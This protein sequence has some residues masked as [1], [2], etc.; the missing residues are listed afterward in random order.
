MECPGCINKWPRV[1][2]VLSSKPMPYLQIWKDKWGILAER[3]VKAAN[4]IGTAVHKAI[5]EE[6]HGTTTIRIRHMFEQWE[7]WAYKNN[8]KPISKETHVWSDKHHYHGTFDA[9]GTLGASDEVIL[10]DWKTSSKLKPDMALQ[11]SAYAQ[12][13]EEMTEVKLKRGVIV[14][15]SKDKPNHKLTV[16][17]YKLDK[18]K[19]REFLQRK[20]DMEANSE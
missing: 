20:K 8:Y 18:L 15:V 11:L 9:I 6:W 7:F 12:A 10:L 16:K 4:A 17:E 5:Q 13:Y 2:E 14:L 3:K 19:F 1:T